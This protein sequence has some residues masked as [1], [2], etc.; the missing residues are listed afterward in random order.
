MTSNENVA[1]KGDE[2][3]IE[4]YQSVR[5]KS[6]D[7]CRPLEVEDMV[8]Q[9]IA[10]VSPPKWHLAHTTWFFVNFLLHRFGIK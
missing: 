9:P 7:I 5:Q 3:L 6:I 8:V 10:F 1:Y 2:S 4:R